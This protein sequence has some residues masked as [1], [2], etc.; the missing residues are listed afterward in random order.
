MSGF[1][2]TY[3]ATSNIQSLFETPMETT[4]LLDLPSKQEAAVK[5]FFSSY[6]VIL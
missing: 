4:G 5:Q 2:L 6:K 3:C 1:G